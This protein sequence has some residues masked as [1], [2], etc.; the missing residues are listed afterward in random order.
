[1]KIKLIRYIY[2]ILNIV[3]WLCGLEEMNGL[4]L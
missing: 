2:C 4:N 3:F 1:M